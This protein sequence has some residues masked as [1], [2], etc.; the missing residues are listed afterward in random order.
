MDVRPNAQLWIFL[1]T[2]AVKGVFYESGTK[3]HNSANRGKISCHYTLFR[4]AAS[5]RN[6]SSQQNRPAALKENEKIK[7]G[8]FFLGKGIK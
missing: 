6:S 1:P 4:C 8:K 7:S 5:S 3:Q 2:L